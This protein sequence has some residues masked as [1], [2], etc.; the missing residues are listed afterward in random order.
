MCPLSA[1]LGPPPLPRQVPTTF[2]RPGSASQRSTSSC[3]SRRRASIQSCPRPRSRPAGLGFGSERAP[4]A[5]RRGAPR[6][7]RHAAR[8][9]ARARSA[10]RSP[11]GAEPS[12]LG[13]DDEHWAGASPRRER[14]KY[15]VKLCP[16][17]WGPGARPV[18]GGSPMAEGTVAAG[19]RAR[20]V[21]TVLDSRRFAGWWW[22]STGLGG[23]AGPGMGRGRWWGCVLP[24][25]CVGCRR[26]RGRCGW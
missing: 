11:L 12:W 21:R 22:S 17:D 14:Q 1:T 7:L 6:A 2:G 13:S 4:Q 26:G 16:P 8:A 24:V 20:L 25:A 3:S 5:G 18:G 15:R 19:G 23:M 9:D 10:L